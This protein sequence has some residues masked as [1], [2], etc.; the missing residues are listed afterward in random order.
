MVSALRIFLTDRRGTS[1]NGSIQPLFA[2]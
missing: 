2:G 1:L